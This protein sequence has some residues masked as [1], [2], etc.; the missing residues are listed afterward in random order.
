MICVCP[1]SSPGLLPLY[2]F[3]SFTL[4][5]CQQSNFTSAYNFIYISPLIPTAIKGHSSRQTQGHELQQDLGFI[6]AAVTNQQC[7]HVCVCV[8]KWHLC[9]NSRIPHCR[10][11][12]IDHIIQFCSDSMNSIIMLGLFGCLALIQ[13]W[14]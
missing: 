2:I 1:W 14:N 9:E 11:I 8:T 3:L 5:C 12:I 6:G 4:C 10:L 7:V 13:T